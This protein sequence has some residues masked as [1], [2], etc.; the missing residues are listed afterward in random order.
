VELWSSSFDPNYE[1][2]WQ[3]LKRKVLS[4][5]R[6]SLSSQWCKFLFYFDEEKICG[7]LTQDAYI[8]EHKL[9]NA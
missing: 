8:L 5:C 4:R 9:Q 6:D 1:K 7:K 2:E 3:A